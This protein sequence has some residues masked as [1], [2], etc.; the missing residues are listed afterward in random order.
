MGDGRQALTHDLKCRPELGDEATTVSFAMHRTGQ[1]DRGGADTPVC[2]CERGPHVGDA[3]R[4]GPGDDE[5]VALGRGAS[6]RNQR[7]SRDHEGL[8]GVLQSSGER[9]DGLGIIARTRLAVGKLF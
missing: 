5:F 9:L 3:G 1:H 8:A 6:G 4:D 7:S 2:G